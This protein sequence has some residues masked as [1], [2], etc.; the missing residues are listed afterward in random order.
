MK[1]KSVHMSCP[2]S[3]GDFALSF[4]D[5]QGS[6]KPLT[7]VFGGPGSGKTTLLT[8][9]AHTRPGHTVAMNLRPTDPPCFARSEWW[10]GLDEPDRVHPLRLWSPNA[11]PELAE[12]DPAARRD[13]A[14]FDKLARE[15]GF[16]FVAFSAMRWF[17]RSPLILSAPERSVRRYDV[18]SNEPLD[19]A[20][21]NDLSR[22][23]KQALVYAAIVRALPEVDGDRHQILG[24]T[25]SRVVNSLTRALGYEYIGISPTSLEPT[26]VGRERVQLPFDALPSAVKHAAA[27]GALTLRAL[28][29]A[30][31]GLNPEL[32]QG[33]VVI[34]QI[35]LHQDASV[36]AILLERLLA[37]LPNVQWIVTTRSQELLASR[38]PDECVALR[39]LDPAGKVSVHWGPDAHVH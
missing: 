2:E 8:A 3:L 12:A 17:S 27:F 15:G 28:W 18:R 19:D 4:D 25:M 30:Y 10:L 33:L 14:L 21:R 20:A 24:D 35:E 9:L 22:D 32:A 36:A 34:D 13:V 6:P 39:R 23:V 16:V 5:E 38:N 26:F 37:A 11:G 1:L 31:P 29:A 7:L